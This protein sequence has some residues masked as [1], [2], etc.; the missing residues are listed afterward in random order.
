MDY[1]KGDFFMHNCKVIAIANQKG[2]VGKT[3]TSVS[4]GA[5][6]AND[7]KKVLIIDFDP[8]GSLTKGLGYR[9]SNSYK[10]SIKD[11][12]FNEITEGTMDYNEAIIKTNENFDLLPSNISLSGTDIQLS[13]VLSRE[14][15]FKRALD[16]IKKNYDYVLIDSNPALNLFTINGLVA[17]DT[18]IIPVQA[19]PYACDGLNDLLHTIATARKQI[20]RN[21]K[22]DGIL[23]T[24]TDTRTNLSKHISNEIREIYGKQIHVFKTEIPRAIKTS[25]AS[26]TGQSPVKYAPN[27]ESTLAYKRLAKE[28]VQIDKKI[29]KTKHESIR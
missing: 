6:L 14:T 19:E 26:L 13:S 23:I 22:I 17:A 8:Q 5:C 29:T 4:L 11:I 12:L 7:N 24:M 21:L 16:K 3:V 27:S 25:E 1:E 10:Y 2:G 15:I 20:N 28:V 9:N 18:I